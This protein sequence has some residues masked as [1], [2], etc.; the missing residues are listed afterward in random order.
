MKEI[1]EILKNS[2]KPYDDLLALYENGELEEICAPLFDLSFTEDGHKNNFFHTLKVLKNVCDKG[3]SYEMKIVAVFHDIGKTPTK[4]KIGENDWSFH[5]HETVG[6]KMFV[7]LCE[8]YNITDIDIDYI[9]KMILYHGRVKMHRDV[10][11]SAIRRLNNDV[12]QDLI[13]D[14]IDFSKCDLTTRNKD[15]SER[16]TSGYDAIRQRILEVRKMDEYDA[17]RSPLTGHVIMD[18]FDNKID[19][20]QIGEIKRSYD[21]ILRNEEMTLEDVIKEIKKLYLGMQ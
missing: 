5:N 9:Y 20:R 1:L 6:A 16:I 2:T 13:F 10:S 14:V 17:W 7:K 4:R 12:G 21:N 11:D 8:T 3:F 19:G 15:K 18:I